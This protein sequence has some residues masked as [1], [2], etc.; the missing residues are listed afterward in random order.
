MVRP[1][2]VIAAVTESTRKGMSSVLTRTQLVRLPSLSAPLAT[3]TTGLPGGRSAIAAAAKAAIACSLRS[4][5][6]TS[7]LQSLMRNSYAVLCLKKKTQ[8]YVLYLQ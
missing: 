5:E 2:A 4:E 7:E 3:C 8:I 1:R 6:H